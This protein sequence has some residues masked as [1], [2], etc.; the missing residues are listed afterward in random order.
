MGAAERS[1]GLLAD[2]AHFD[3]DTKIVLKLYNP[4]KPGIVAV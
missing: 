1:R 2:S 4:R 3:L